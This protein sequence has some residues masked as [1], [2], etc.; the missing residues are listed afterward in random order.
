VQVTDVE[1]GHH[2]SANA[3]IEDGSDFVL[4]WTNTN[5]DTDEHLVMVTKLDTTGSEVWSTPLTGVVAYHVGNIVAT[6]AG[7]AVALVEDLPDPARDAVMLVTLDAA[8]QV[9]SKEQITEETSLGGIYPNW[10]KVFWTGTD[11]VLMWGGTD[12]SGALD[13]NASGVFFAKVDTDGNPVGAP[14][15]I[16]DTG[17]VSSDVSGAWTG[18]EFGVTWSAGNNLNLYFGRLDSSGQAIGSPQT[19]VGSGN[20]AISSSAVWTGEHYG[21]VWLEDGPS[22]VNRFDPC[23]VRLD[24]QGSPLGSSSRLTQDGFATGPSIAWTGSSYGIVWSR[25]VSEGV[26]EPPSIHF[27][28]VDASGQVLGT[29][30][31]MEV[32]SADVYPLLVWSNGGYAMVW[33]SVPDWSDDVNQVMFARE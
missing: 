12:G 24:S 19:V 1:A 17:D 23:T 33:T 16:A 32:V 30:Q 11:Y 7:Y 29:A 3:F 27:A 8:G 4:L 28:S 20:A 9:L 10:P 21:L 22:G 6:G 31:V 26:V 18:S 15:V 5:V 25:Y 2:G 13:P 14:A